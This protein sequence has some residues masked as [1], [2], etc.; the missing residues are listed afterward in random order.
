MIEA[1]DLALVAMKD[2]LVQMEREIPTPRF[3]KSAAGYRGYRFTERLPQQ[4]IFLKTVRIFSA[5]QSL[6]LTLDAG[7]LLDAGALMCILDEVG[8]DVQFLTAPL[9][10]RLEWEVLHTRFLADFFEEE[11]DH[12]EILKSSQKRDRVSR[13]HIR[14]YIAR[15]HGH[16]DTSSHI[17]VLKLIDN[18]F[19]GYIHGAAVHIMDAY[20]SEGFE[21]P[22]SSHHQPLLDIR[23]QFA[24]YLHRALMD[25]ALAAKALGCEATF[26]RLFQ[27]ITSTFTD[28]GSLR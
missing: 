7:L 12:P 20:N 3:V 18:A 9:V 16:G 26:S 4:A 11:F 15:V 8:S 19:S 28:E 24:T 21:I 23:D 22:A 2:A 1:Y 5:I 17:D 14:A 10:F 27:F 13:K 25:C 6:Q